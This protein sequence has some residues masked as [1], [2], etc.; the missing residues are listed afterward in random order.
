MVWV[1]GSSPATEGYRTPIFGLPWVQSIMQTPEMRQA[2]A[3]CCGV[4]TE[5]KDLVAIVRQ[6]VDLVHRAP[7]PK[8]PPLSERDTLHIPVP[9]TNAAAPSTKGPPH[10]TWTPWSGLRLHYP[11]T[12]I[13]KRNCSHPSHF[14]S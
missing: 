2:M 12:M 13:H 4:A 14:Q 3:R 10:L 1:A 7:T 9:P 8:P 6:L 11:W 5:H